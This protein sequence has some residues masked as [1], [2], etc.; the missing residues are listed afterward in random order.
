MLAHHACMTV[1]LLQ[2]TRLHSIR[3]VTS[4]MLKIQ[5]VMAYEPNSTLLLHC[6]S[7]LFHMGTVLYVLFKCVP[8]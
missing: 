7:V 8:Q 5:N 6:C 2:D 4:C 1:E 3:H